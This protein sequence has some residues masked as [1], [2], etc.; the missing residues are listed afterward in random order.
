MESNKEILIEKKTFIDKRIEGDRSKLTLK[1]VNVE[2]LLLKGTFE[3]VII[4]NVK[5]EY[6]FDCN[7]EIEDISINE[8]KC[9]YFDIYGNIDKLKMY[10]T[11]IEFDFKINQPII[12]LSIDDF[13]CKNFIVNK[14]IDKLT[15]NEALIETNFECNAVIKDV[16]AEMFKILGEFT[17][18]KSIYNRSNVL[19]YSKERPTVLNLNASQVKEY[20]SQE[21][22]SKTSDDS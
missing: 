5:V 17:E 9:K 21:M 14:S 3:S 22:M 1:N 7:A 8:L 6:G 18:R 19:K 2:Y 12:G 13:R 16:D 15:I 4:E 11:Q 10:K 20:I